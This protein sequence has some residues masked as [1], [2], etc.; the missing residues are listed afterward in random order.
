M[1]KLSSR[2]KKSR[3]LASA[4]QRVYPGKFDEKKTAK[5]K[6]AR[7]FH[8]NESAEKSSL[9]IE[10]IEPIP[11]VEVKEEPLDDYEVAE[12]VTEEASD[13]DGQSTCIIEETEIKTEPVDEIQEI[14]ITDFCDL[15]D[16]ATITEEEIGWDSHYKRFFCIICEYSTTK[17]KNYFSKKKSA[18]L[19]HLKTQHGANRVGQLQN[20]DANQ[21]ESRPD[22]TLFEKRELTNLRESIKCL[23]KSVKAYFTIWPCRKGL[24]T[25]L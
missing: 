1:S 9:E 7:F 3:Q 8:Q 10:S 25:F 19:S 11:E 22:K 16:P 12:I 14:E 6:D 24:Q 20:E 17:Q 21:Y 23:P 18:I 5:A 2:M 15:I 13:D 4:R